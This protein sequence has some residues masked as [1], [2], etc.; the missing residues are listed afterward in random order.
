MG[1]GSISTQELRDVMKQ[2]GQESTEQEIADMIREVDENSD[3]EIDFEEF[4]QMMTKKM[5]NVNPQDEL[6]EAFNVFDKDGS[7]TI[8][9]SELKE[10]M[11]NLGESLTDDQIAEMIKE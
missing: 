10:V 6:R 7:G 5:A 2:L 4:Q 3:G 8:T 1:G 11:K 9:V